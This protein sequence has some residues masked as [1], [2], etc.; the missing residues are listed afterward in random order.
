ML[1]VSAMSGGVTAGKAAALRVTFGVARRTLERWR[2]WWRDVFV[3]TPFWSVERARFMLPVAQSDLPSSL[4][5][6][7]QT[8]DARARLALCLHFLAPLTVP[9]V[10]TQCDVR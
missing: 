7:F 3:R 5:D 9:T 10:I 1:I 2:S 4:L 8:V 6:R